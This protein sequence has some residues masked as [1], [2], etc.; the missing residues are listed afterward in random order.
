MVHG[1]GGGGVFGGFRPRRVVGHRRGASSGG[2]VSRAAAGR[3]YVASACAFNALSVGGWNALDLF[4]SEA[5]P[6]EVRSTAMGALG[7]CGRL[8]SAIGTGVAGAAVGAG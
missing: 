3:L 8:G 7:A 6:T 5:F 2:G 4:T 1:V